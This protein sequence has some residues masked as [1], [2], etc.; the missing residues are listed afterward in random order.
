MKM[1]VFTNQD[2]PSIPFNM[3]TKYIEVVD[4]EQKCSVRRLAEEVQVSVSTALKAIHF[5]KEGQ[6]LIK[7]PGHQGIDSRHL[8]LR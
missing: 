5:Y 2:E 1:E 3:P 6:I 7:C 4:G 8:L